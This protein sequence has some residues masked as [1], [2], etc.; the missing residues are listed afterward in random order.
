MFI[1]KWVLLPGL[2]LGLALVAWALLIVAGRNPLPFPDP[3]SRI[4]SAASPEAKDAIVGLLAQHGVRERFRAD[5]GGVLR[6]ILADGTI[7]N[8]SPPE[9]TAKVGGATSAIGLVS[10]DPAAAAEAA[11]IFLR[12]RGFAAEVV[13]EIE[14]GLPISFVLTDALP[15]TAIN[16]R[17]HLLRMPRPQPATKQ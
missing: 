1:P 8:H 11:A 7:I 2:A 5:S 16:F 13:E 3:G 9:I 15:G 12:S 17:P 10:D 6:S 4:F 14:P